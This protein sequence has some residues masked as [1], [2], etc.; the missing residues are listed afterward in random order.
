[1]GSQA[2]PSLGNVEQKMK[3]PRK[4]YGEPGSTSACVSSA[5]GHELTVDGRQGVGNGRDRE[6]GN[7]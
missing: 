6:H 2:K 1:M 5:P 4:P 7:E 3:E